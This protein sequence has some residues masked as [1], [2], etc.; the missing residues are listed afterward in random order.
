MK[1]EHYITEEA[2]AEICKR[3]VEMKF[4]MQRLFSHRSRLVIKKIWKQ[5][6]I[7]EQLDATGND[8][9]SI[10]L[11]LEFNISLMRSFNITEME[12][13]SVDFTQSWVKVGDLKQIEDA[14]ETIHVIDDKIQTIHWLIEVLTLGDKYEIRYTFCSCNRHSLY[15]TRRLWWKLKNLRWLRSNKRSWLNNKK[16]K[17]ARKQEQTDKAVELYRSVQANQN[18]AIENAVKNAN[19]YRDA[20]PRLEGT[21]VISHPDPML[22]AECLQGSGWIWITFMGKKNTKVLMNL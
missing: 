11:R 20:S 21:S 19:A 10:V 13:R 5:L 4:G 17:I 7:P 22:N 2:K 6:G 18:T 12:K 1:I 15:G 16:D 8:V 3:W 9:C 14:I